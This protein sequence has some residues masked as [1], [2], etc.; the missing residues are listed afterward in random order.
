VADPEPPEL[1]GQVEVAVV[2]HHDGDPGVEWQRAGGTLSDKTAR[3]E[4][5]LTQAEIV[6]AIRAGK[7][8]YRC[9]S[10]Y[11]NPCLRLLR[12]EVESLVRTERGAAYLAKEQA[13]TE[14]A[15]IDSEMRLLRTK[16]AALE[17]RRAKLGP[18][19]G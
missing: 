4:F 10:I 16:L 2:R 15:R 5:G 18:R 7:L 6:S 17:A 13:K 1:Q 12:R 14:L 9:T 3:K 19:G 11:G 8:Q